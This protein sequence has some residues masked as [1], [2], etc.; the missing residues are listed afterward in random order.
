MSKRESQEIRQMW[1][2]IMDETGYRARVMAEGKAEGKAS[3]ISSVLTIIKGLQK[4]IPLSQLAE[5]AEMSLVEAERIQRELI[6][7]T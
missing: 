7:A 5:E 6:P 1:E 2:Q 4:N 3:G